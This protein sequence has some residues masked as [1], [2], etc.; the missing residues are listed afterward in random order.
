MSRLTLAAVLMSLAG[1]S[2]ADCTVAEMVKMARG[3]SGRNVIESRCDSAVTD[4]PRCTFNR[5]LQIAVTKKSEYDVN[6]ECGPCDR[7][8]CMVGQN[9]C[10]IARLTRGA[11]EGDDCWCPSPYGPVS[12]QLICF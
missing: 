12:G 1:T 9:T 4:A 10:R 3:G 6:D 7:P 8:Q 5:A 11:K 2:F